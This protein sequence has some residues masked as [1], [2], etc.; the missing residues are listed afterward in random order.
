M[1]DTGWQCKIFCLERFWNGSLVT[2]GK[3]FCMSHLGFALISAINA[4]NKIQYIV[5]DYSKSL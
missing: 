1:K 3:F 4:S 5:K 2:V